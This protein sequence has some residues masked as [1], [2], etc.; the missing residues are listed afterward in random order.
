MTSLEGV[1]VLDFTRVLAGPYCTM[2]LG[3]L[4]A[5][6]L[7]VESPQGDETRAWGPPWAGDGAERE[8]AYYLAVNRNKRSLTLNL[9]QPAAQVIAQQLAA[10]SQIVL[11]NFKPG[12]MAKFGLDYQSLKRHNPTLVYVSITGYGQTGPYSDRPGYDHIIQ[13]M[14]GLMSITGPPDGEGYKVGVALVDVISGLF[15]LSGVLAA[16]RHAER[17]GEGQHLDI[18]LMDAQ[19][20]ALVNVAS[21]TLVSGKTPGRY[22]NAHSTIV[23]YQNFRAADKPFALAVGN[24][25]QYRTLCS[26]IERPDLASDERYATNPA[27]VVNRAG[28]VA[29]LQVIFGAQ[30][31]DYWVELCLSVGIPAGPVQTVIQAL[32]DDHARARHLIREAELPN[33]QTLKM[34]ASPLLPDTP[35]AVRYPPPQLGQHTSQILAERLGL[36]PSEIVRLRDNG[37]I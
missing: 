12:Q 24:D 21:S 1:R 5:D 3:D 35:D 11:E 10:Q 16:L 34:V 8:S 19:L 23:P 33:G 17:T 29:E 28:L 4:G 14:S 13:A 31:A 6:V 36:S 18:A 25:G 20:S 7:K 9:K 37:L 22:G 26:L 32:N 2:L 15:A 27:R 30:S